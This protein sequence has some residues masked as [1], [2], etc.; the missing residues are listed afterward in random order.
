M[1]KSRTGV[2]DWRFDSLI[3]LDPVDALV[4]ALAE[5]SG[6]PVPEKIERQR[7]QLQDAMVDTHFMLGFARIAIAAEPD[8]LYGLAGLVS[9]MGCAVTAA[10]APAKS[11]VLEAVPTAEVKLGDLQDLEHAIQ[12]HGADLILSN[13]HAADTARRLGL[14]LVRVGFPQYDLIGGYQKLWIGYRGTRQVLFDLAN[15]LVQ[16]GHPEVPAYRSIYADRHD[17]C[18]A[19]PETRPLH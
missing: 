17:E 7:A 4:A 2:P 13:S 3:G 5:I 9:G 1:L 14:P 19:T 11:P 6:Q 12:A 8:L 10:V 15:T 18:H 16:H